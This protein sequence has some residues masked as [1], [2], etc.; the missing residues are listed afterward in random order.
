MAYSAIPIVGGGA[1]GIALYAISGV[2]YL[3]V[4]QT[5]TI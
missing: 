1:G 2:S 3:Q 4:S 5:A